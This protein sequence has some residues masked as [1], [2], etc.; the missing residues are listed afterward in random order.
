MSPI[1]VGITQRI[2][3]ISNGRICDALEH[4][5]QNFFTARG[6]DLV[7]IPNCLP[8]PVQFLQQHRIT[9]LVLSGGGDVRANVRRSAREKELCPRDAT[10]AMII[11]CAVRKKMPL[12]G[13]CRGAQ[14]LNVY[15]GGTLIALKKHAQESFNE[16]VASRHG[17]ALTDRKLAR[18]FRKD[19]IS[20]NSYHAYGILQDCLAKPLNSFAIAPDGTIEGFTHRS[21]PIVGVMWHPERTMPATKIDDVLVG[22][23]LDKKGYWRV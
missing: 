22:N 10:E 9:H 2:V 18:T 20:V 16:H 7:P 5:Y 15:F 1:R 6:V 21:L 19:K 8:R 4:T 23:F 14:A 3:T 13:I 12:L 11:A 17:I